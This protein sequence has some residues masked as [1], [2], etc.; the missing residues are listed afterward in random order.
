MNGDL[1]NPSNPTE[2]IGRAQ[3]RTPYRG[4]ASLV[5]QSAEIRVNRGCDRNLARDC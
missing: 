5:E 4:M 3:S 1:K 2:R